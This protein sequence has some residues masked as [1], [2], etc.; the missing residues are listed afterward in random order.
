MDSGRSKHRQSSSKTCHVRESHSLPPHTRHSVRKDQG[1]NHHSPS[2][3]AQ[4]HTVIKY[5]DQKELK[6]L[7]ISSVMELRS[8]TPKLRFVGPSEV[9]PSLSDHR[10]GRDDS[11]SQSES[12]IGPPLEITIHS[13]SPDT[14][15]AV[16]TEDELEK[17]LPYWLSTPSLDRPLAFTPEVLK[18]WGSANTDCSEQA[19]QFCAQIREWKNTKMELQNVLM[20][21]YE[22]MHTLKQHV[23]SNE[24]MQDHLYALHNQVKHTV[25]WVCKASLDVD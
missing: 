5:K 2:L 12:M 21:V 1:T 23:M 7:S 17:N 15:Q 14:D 4:N 9:V 16:D 6:E 24:V 25:Q 10:D 3:E 19:I 20:Q 13:P 22:E 11:A 18:I 8:P